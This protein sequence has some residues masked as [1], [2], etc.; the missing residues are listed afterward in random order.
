MGSRKWPGPLEVG[1]SPT[2]LVQSDES[3]RSPVHAIHKKREREKKRSTN[4]A[5]TSQYLYMYRVPNNSAHPARQA[6]RFYGFGIS[7]MQSG[8]DDNLRSKPVP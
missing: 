7:R 2:R 6:M 5:D 4:H 8:R 3:Q 1:Q